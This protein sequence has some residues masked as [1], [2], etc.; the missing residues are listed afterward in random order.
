MKQS[1]DPQFGKK[2]IRG[3]L[4]GILAVITVVILSVFLYAQHLLNAVQRNIDAD[5]ET[6]SESQLM[7]ELG[8]E[9][10]PA[11]TGAAERFPANMQN[12]DTDV[13]NILLIG[14]D[15]RP[16]QKTA[17]RSDAMILCTLNPKQ[18]TLTLSSFMR[19][20]YVP[21]PGKKNNRINAAYAM[22]G[23]KLL[24]QCI[25]E[26]FGITIDGNVAVDFEAF[27]HVID[28]MG[29]VDV[30]LTA[31]EAEYL[32]TVTYK[33]QINWETGFSNG[34]NHLDGNQALA[35]ARIRK[36][37]GNDFGRTN[38][39]RKVLSA[40]IQ[41]VKSQ[42]LPQLHRL[43]TDIA[44]QVNTDMTNGQ[45]LE[46]AVEIL[47]CLGSYRIESLQIPANGAYSSATVRGMQ[48]LLPDME[49]NRKILQDI[50]S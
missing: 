45:I 17:A 1:N 18:K 11:V 16:G 44:G 26:N 39:Q 35:Y 19:D 29:G 38:R 48:V 36:I 14:Q 31:K 30:E 12:T 2:R 27:T 23:T 24:N 5:L 37:S 9:E 33:D 8:I 28:R 20:M 49:K 3:A 46:Y 21:I 10:M 42:N 32:N 47:P 40:L 22:G 4:W 50:M 7:E 6:I 25:E 34:V 41:K 43:L 15:R 13:I